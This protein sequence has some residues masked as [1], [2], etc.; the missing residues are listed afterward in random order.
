M[1]NRRPVLSSSWKNYEQARAKKILENPGW[2]EPYQDTEPLDTEG[3]EL[4]P[5]ETIK[6]G[7]KNQP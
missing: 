6:H 4:C 1:G 3:E 5:Q 7:Q 2:E